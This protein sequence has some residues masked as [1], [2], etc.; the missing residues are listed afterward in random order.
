MIDQEEGGVDSS[1]LEEELDD[2]DDLLV[3]PDP[4]AL[5]VEPPLL[6]RP[7]QPD[8]SSI[9]TYFR[10]I[11]RNTLLTAAEEKALAQQAQGGNLKARNTL[12]EKNL[13]LVISIARKYLGLGMALEDLIQEGNLGLFRAIEGFEPA[14]GYRFSTYATWW[15]RQHITRSI[16]CKV[17]PIRVPVHTHEAY[18]KIKQASRQLQQELGHDPTHEQIALHLG[19]PVKK[20]A[21]TYAQMRDVL[22]LDMP[23]GTERD[24]GTLMDVMRD[25]DLSIEET[26]I[27]RQLRESLLMAMAILTERE[28]LIIRARYGFDDGIPQSLAAIGTK[29][30]IT[31][32]RVRQIEAKALK[33]LRGPLA[34]RSLDAYYAG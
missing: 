9:D 6:G 29:F 28:Q 12:A 18:H 11:S 23:S 5:E 32:E 25:Q 4:T 14:R 21:L 31:R 16:S 17:R 1:L 10:S 8:D 30:G 3:E 26:V 24:D 2:P 13:R 15:V 27:D 34:K 20:V 33:R 19:M 7:I 22:S